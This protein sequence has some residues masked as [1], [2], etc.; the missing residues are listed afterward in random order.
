MEDM[1]VK[2][3]LWTNSPFLAVFTV[4]TRG[5]AVLAR[6]FLGMQFSRSKDYEDHENERCEKW[7][8]WG[9][10]SSCGLIL[11]V[12]TVLT[13]VFAVLVSGF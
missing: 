10:R 1:G 5:F 4:L 8:I 3:Q 13:R 6:G 9:L 7:K 2:K 12:F 11:A